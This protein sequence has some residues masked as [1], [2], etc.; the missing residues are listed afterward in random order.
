MATVSIDLEWFRCPKGYRIVRATEIAR[1]SG[2]DPESY[3]DEDWI[4][5]YT[6][7]RVS[8]RPFDKNDMI[9]VAFSRL[10]TPE[11]LLEFINLYGPITRSSPQWGDS[12]PTCLRWSRRFY[13]LLSCKEKGPKK[14]AS[15][16]NSQIRESHARGNKR[17]IGVPLPADYD[18]GVLNQWIG[19]AELVAD[20]LR[21][22]HLRITTEVLIGGL[23]WQLGQKL[24]GGTIIRVCR[25]CSAPFE[26]G[27]GTGRHMDATFCCNEHKVRY[28]SLARS[29]RRK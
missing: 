3:P 1:A 8:Y 5:P 4:V 14:L 29:K 10:R 2:E 15:V 27:P 23:W 7:E 19:Q 12:V 21:G 13:D 26:T 9:C 6:S 20:P 11:S 22:V 16:F 17:D 24:S 25:H 28:F 18:F